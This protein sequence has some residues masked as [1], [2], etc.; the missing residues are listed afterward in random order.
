MRGPF[1]CVCEV[2]D[3]G[4][5][6]D[7]HLRPVPG[8]EQTLQETDS[9]VSLWLDGGFL[10]IK[11]DCHYFQPLHDDKLHHQ[12]GRLKP[13]REDIRQFANRCGLLGYD[14]FLY[15]PE[16]EGRPQAVKTGESLQFWKQE[17][18]KMSALLDLWDSIQYPKKQ[19]NGITSQCV[20]V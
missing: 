3:E 18:E 12:F 14:I 15:Y 16:Q 10:G 11:Y 17:I 1:A 4:Y 6:W 13:T 8:P 5:E 2:R 9:Q 20:L 7:T 19:H